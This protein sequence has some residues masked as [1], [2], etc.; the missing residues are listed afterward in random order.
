ML[1]GALSLVARQFI[2]RSN[3]HSIQWMKRHEHLSGLAH[4]PMPSLVGHRDSV[5]GDSSQYS[6]R[7]LGCGF[8]EVM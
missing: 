8:I 3:E 5:I 6:Y 7:G 4:Q 2:L 1:T